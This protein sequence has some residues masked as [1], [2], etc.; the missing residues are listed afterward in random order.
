MACNCMSG[1]EM[2]SLIRNCGFTVPELIITLGIVSIV[3]AV[4]VPGLSATIKNNRLAGTLNNMIADIHF[5]RSEAVKRHVRVILCRSTDPNWNNPECGGET[6][7]WTGGYIV[8]ADDGNNNNNTYQ[9]GTDELLRRGQAA[10]S[11]VRLRTN[12]TWNNNLE[13]NPDGTTNEGG[14]IATMSICDNRGSDKG[15]KIIVAPNGIP[16]MYANN[17]DTCFP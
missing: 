9:P 13:F 5:A 4:A 15:R 1:S 17:I 11:G 14:S 7:N 3:L 8:F 16:K 12:W 6:K 2:R 10:A